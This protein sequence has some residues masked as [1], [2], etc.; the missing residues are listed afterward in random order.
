MVFV[1]SS[2]ELT[3]EAIEKRLDAL[4]TRIDAREKT[5]LPIYHQV[6]KRQ[7]NGTFFC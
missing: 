3:N 1:R 2:T 5:L 4:A 6:E 7:T